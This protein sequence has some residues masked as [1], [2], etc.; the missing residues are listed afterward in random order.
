[1]I[2]RLTKVV[3]LLTVLSV[4]PIRAQVS[5]SSITGVV[6]DSSGAIIANAKVEAK[7]DDTG[8]VFEQNTTT[9]GTYTFPSLTP[10][11]YSITVTMSGF[12]KF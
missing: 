6:T 10:G 4:F 8:V 7:N 9:A 2:G 11:S 5:T 12:Q 1:M 3:S